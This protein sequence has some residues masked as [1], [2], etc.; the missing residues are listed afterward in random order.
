MKKNI[1][2]IGGSHGIGNALAKLIHSDYNI[3]VA[4][5]N[6]KGLE[7]IEATYINY[8]VENSI[9][10]TENLPE[11]LDGFVYCPGSINLKPF[12]MLS[13]ESFEQDMKLNFF[14]L[15]KSLKAVTELLKKSEQA[16]LIFFST[17]AVKVGMPFHTSVAASKGA[18][19]GFA[20][21]LAAEY[22]PKFRVNVIAPSLTD[23]PLAEK[24][25]GN[26]KKREKM[27]ERHPLKRVGTPDDIA[28][29]ASFLLSEDSS[30]VTGQ[31]LG[32]DGGMS[33]LN[34]S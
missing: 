11:V 20:K 26:E 24:L 6:E 4:S 7:N 22:A 3:Y 1:L 27:D 18:I 10:D 34:V 21:S 2:L 15:I 9:L 14:G 31:I 19:E 17:V 16:S 23:T 29:I 8:D 25:L 12:K 33:T 13:E 5:R 30:W 32:V 28:K